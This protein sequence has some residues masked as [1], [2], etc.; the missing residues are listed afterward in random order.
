MSCGLRKQPFAAQNLQRALESQDQGAVE[1]RSWCAPEHSSEQ[2]G[3]AGV[4]PPAPPA[5]QRVLTV[6]EGPSLVFRQLSARY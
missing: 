4:F 2:D 1:N 5:C 6:L 3:T